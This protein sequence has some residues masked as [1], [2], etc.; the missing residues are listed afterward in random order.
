[1]INLALSCLSMA[2][3][4]IKNLQDI[5]FQFYASACGLNSTFLKPEKNLSVAASLSQRI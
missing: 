1:M 2:D 3:P 5:F 4:V